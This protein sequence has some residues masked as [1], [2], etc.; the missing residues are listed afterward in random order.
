VGTLVTGVEIVCDEQFSIWN[1]L[2]IGRVANCVQCNPVM[3]GDNPRLG[4]ECG[5]LTIASRRRSISSCTRSPYNHRREL[6]N[7]HH[8]RYIAPT[9]D[10]SLTVVFSVLVSAL[11]GLL[12]LL[13]DSYF[14]IN[15]VHHGRVTDLAIEK[16]GP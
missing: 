10:R 16:R 9:M 13:A 11:L 4:H 7:P 6:T 14:Q 3:Y 5:Q 8:L 12:A 15:P 2:G 1:A